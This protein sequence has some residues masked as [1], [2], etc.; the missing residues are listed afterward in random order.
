PE[1]TMIDFNQFWAEPG[2]LPGLSKEETEAYLKQLTDQYGPGAATFEPTGDSMFVPGPGVS[3]EQID[4][5]EHNRGVRLPDVLRQAFAKQNGGFVYDSHLRILPLE[6]ID[7]PSD[8]FW[9]YAC[10]EEED[11]PDRNL[12][13]RFAEEQ[14]FSGELFLNYNVQG[15]Q[16]EPGVMVYH[17]DPGDLNRHSKS[18]TKFLTRM[19]ETFEAPSVDW[20]ET[21]QLQIVAR[22]PVDLS[23]VYNAP[24]ELEQVLARQE[25]CL[26]LFR[27]E[28]T[29]EGDKLT[30][31]TLPL[32]HSRDFAMIQRHRPAPVTHALLL[33]PEQCDGVA[34]IESR[35]M[36]SG[37]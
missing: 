22:E 12:I 4:A 33:Q 13:F 3:V 2:C 7:R 10:C 29:P 17:S 18:V 25:S 27:R 16:Q 6:E 35:Q 19:L 9:E 26:V 24:A 5:W 36:R 14:E 8:E 11:V 31:T 1:L 23:P 20:S 21:E 34:E 37:R 32:P 30:R 28:R 15:P